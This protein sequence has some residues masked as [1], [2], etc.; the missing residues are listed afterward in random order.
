M[1]VSH[2][3]WVGS[4]F[5]HRSGEKIAVLG[6]SHYLGGGRD[7]D[8]MTTD[9]LKSIVNNDHANH[10]ENRNTP[11]FKKIATVFGKDNG[12]F[13]NDVVFLNLIP[14]AIGGREEMYDWAD[15]DSAVAGST[16]LFEVLAKHNISKLFVFSAKAWESLPAP[17]LLRDVPLGSGSR[18]G[19]NAFVQAPTTVA[20]HLRHPQFAPPVELE[21]LG[22]AVQLAMERPAAD[23]LAEIDPTK[24]MP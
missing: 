15:H 10:S 23:F 14:N 17:V 2:H 13:W 19:F 20:F 8:A 16:R 22:Q 18:Y 21:K 4:A 1:E 24:A 11:F 6:Y 3:H 5:D 7:H 9:L 12:T